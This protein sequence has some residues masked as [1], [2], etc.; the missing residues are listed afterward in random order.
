MKLDNTKDI[1][2]ELL[3]AASR[4][5]GDRNIE[6]PSV[7][8][9]RDVNAGDYDHISDEEYKK[10]LDSVERLSA[11]WQ[12]MQTKTV[13][14]LLINALEDVDLSDEDVE[15]ISA[16]LMSAY[17]KTDHDRIPQA[18]SDRSDKTVDMEHLRMITGHSA[19]GASQ[20]EPWDDMPY[21]SEDDYEAEDE[22]DTS[23][24]LRTPA[25]IYQYLD[26]RV[27]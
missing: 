2:A 26:E 8:F 3:R 6:N 20:K 23:D 4:G 16:A 1:F 17:I 18:A 25:S 27:Y 22:A 14:D 11:P 19:A 5:Y 21:D 13:K 7:S 10:I 9:I 12:T 24:I 15:D